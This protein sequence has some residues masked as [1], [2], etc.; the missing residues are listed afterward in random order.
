MTTPLSLASLD[1]LPADIGRPAYRRDRQQPGVVH[2]GTGNSGAPFAVYLDD[3]LNA[4]KDHDWALVGAGVSD[5]GGRPRT[6]KG[7]DWL[8]TVVEQDLG[9][10]RRASPAR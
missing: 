7:Q 9:H 6:L 5:R 2:I 3:L 4:G 8:T 1:T 10:K